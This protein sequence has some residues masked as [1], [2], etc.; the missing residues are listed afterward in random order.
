ME[1]LRK[2]VEDTNEDKS[3]VEEKQTP[4]PQGMAR[5]DVINGF[6]LENADKLERVIYGE[7]AR[8]GQ[9][10][11]GLIDSY[12]DIEDIPLELV[13]AHY[14]KIGGYI[15]KGVGGDERVKVKNG[16]FWD[17][18]KHKPREN[19]EILYMFNI[20]GNFIE[21]DDPA[22]LAQAITKVD[23]M[24]AAEKQRSDNRRARARAKKLTR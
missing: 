13:L 14:D 21:V 17:I 23:K 8:S 20:G 2:N 9:A 6:V 10:T 24:V 15:T 3:I 1:R 12:P 18:R 19:S 22:Q 11:G 4:K 16:S 5:F 7:P